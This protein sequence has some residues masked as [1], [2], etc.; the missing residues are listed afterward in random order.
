MDW[1]QIAVVAVSAI[2]AGI[3]TPLIMSLLRKAGIVK[4]RKAEND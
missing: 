1:K 4:E 3:F 2:I